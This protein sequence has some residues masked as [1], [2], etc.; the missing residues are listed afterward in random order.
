MAK[1]Y[2]NFLETIVKA[3]LP[4][5][6][7]DIDVTMDNQRSGPTGIYGVTRIITVKDGTTIIGVYQDNNLNYD[8]ERE[9]SS[10][11]EETAVTLIDQLSQRV[12]ERAIVPS[13]GPNHSFQYS[14]I[15]ANALICQEE[16]LKTATNAF[17]DLKPEDAFQKMYTDHE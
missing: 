16:N 8:S 9:L 7:Y 11:Q 10:D 3:L 5:R 2:N 14:K 15:R 12:D 17:P 1:D 6:R 4:E 13:G